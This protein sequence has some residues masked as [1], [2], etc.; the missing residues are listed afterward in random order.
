[1]LGVVI[2]APVVVFTL[3]PVANV[4]VL[5]PVVPLLSDTAVMVMLAA[6]IT[7]NL[8]AVAVSVV[9]PPA[10]VFF[11][12]LTAFVSVIPDVV[13]AEIVPINSAVEFVYTYHPA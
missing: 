7:Y 10:V 6:A 3:V 8:L 5:D 12:F 11:E 2:A 1:M 9:N 4:P 13:I